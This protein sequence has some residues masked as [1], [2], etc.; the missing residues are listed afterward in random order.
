MS[1]RWEQCRVCPWNSKQGSDPPP[2][3]TRGVRDRLPLVGT[4]APSL[5]PSREGQCTSCREAV[6]SG[7]NRPTQAPPLKLGPNS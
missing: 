1:L 2:P 3:P 7:K 5:S 6:F 4:K